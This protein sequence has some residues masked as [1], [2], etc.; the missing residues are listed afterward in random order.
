[1]SCKRD[2]NLVAK[3]RKIIVGI[4]ISQMIDRLIDSHPHPSVAPINKYIGKSNPLV[5]LF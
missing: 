2:K 4:L 3:V 1:M 5:A